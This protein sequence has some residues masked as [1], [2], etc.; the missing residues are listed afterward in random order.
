MY[1]HAHIINTHKIDLSTLYYVMHVT[2]LFGALLA[3]AG[4]IG[5]MS[6]LD[7]QDVE[8]FVRED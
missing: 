1:R 3:L 6:T 5:G 4:A 2:I 7:D 8:D